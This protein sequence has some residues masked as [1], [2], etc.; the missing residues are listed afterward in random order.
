MCRNGQRGGASSDPGWH[1]FAVYEDFCVVTVRSHQ[2]CFLVYL[3]L[4]QAGLAID[5]FKKLKPR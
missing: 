2:Y 3:L 4:G 1:T 5:D